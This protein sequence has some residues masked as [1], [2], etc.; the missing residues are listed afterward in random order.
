MLKNI[1][2]IINKNKWKLIILVVVVLL[3]LIGTNLINGNDDE[4]VTQ[5][6]V[7]QDLVSSISASGM[8]EGKNQAALHFQ[9]PG[10]LAWIGVS[11]GDQV[12]KWQAI[13]KLDTVQLNANLQIARSNLRAAEATLDRVYDSV[14]D[15]DDDE[16]FTQK[17]TRTA[18]EVAKDKAYDSVLSAQD[19]LSNATLIAPFAGTVVSISDN[20]TPGANIALTDTITIAD[21]SEFK[22]AAQVDEVDFGKI[23]LGQKAKVYLDAFPDETFEGTVSYISKAGV[24]TATG[25][26]TIPIEVQFDPNG[27]NLVVGLSGDVEFILDQKEN[28]LVVPTNYIEQKDDTSIVYLLTENGN[29]VEQEVSTGLTTLTEVEITK[30]LTEGQLLVLPD[31]IKK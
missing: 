17:E 12:K 18:A 11:Q 19:A 10:K 25:G 1:G 14:K 22:F 6:V 24:R 15:N 23:E 9:T 28:A 27:H 16:S 7:R 3:G 31:R 30:G 5:K 8:V 21:V 29:R 13:A 26:V 4:L 20:L 2:Q